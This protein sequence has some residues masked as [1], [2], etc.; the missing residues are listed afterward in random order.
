MVI[1]DFNT[2]M[3]LGSAQILAIIIFKFKKQDMNL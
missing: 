2:I 1:L 3:H